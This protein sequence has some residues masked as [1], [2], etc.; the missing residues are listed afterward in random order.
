MYHG[1]YKPAKS[2]IGSIKYI[3]K[4]D[5]NPLEL[6]DMDYKQ[7]IKAKESKTAILGKRLIA[8]T[9]LVELVKENPEMLKDFKKWELAIEAFFLAEERNKPDCKDFIPNNWDLT[10]PI[11]SEKKRHYWFWSS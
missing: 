6:G 1:D 5:E 2:A 10:L 9:P 3:T 8:K 11:L 7:E 4:E